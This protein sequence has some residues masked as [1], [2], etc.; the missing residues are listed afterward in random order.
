[1]YPYD[2]FGFQCWRHEVLNL[3]STTQECDVSTERF[4]ISSNYR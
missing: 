4:E 3:D 2:G 1:M